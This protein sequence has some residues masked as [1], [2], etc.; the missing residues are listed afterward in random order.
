MV[1]EKKRGRPR[2]VGGTVKTPIGKRTPCD[3]RPDGL[4]EREKEFCAQYIIDFIG[5]HAAITAGYAPK[6]AKVRASELLAREDIQAEISRQLV[7]RSKRTE[8]TQDMVLERW[9]QIATADP[10]DLVQYRRSACRYCHGDDHAYHWCDATEFA[11]ACAK[12]RDDH[13]TEPDDAGG[14]GYDHSAAPHPECPRCR[15]AGR[16]GLFITDTR[17]AKGPARLLYAGAKQTKDGIE[18]KFQD[19]AKAMENVA[20]HLGMFKQDGGGEQPGASVEIKIIGGLP[21]DGAA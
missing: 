10:N 11:E 21:D 16:G 15:G 8:I 6:S 13:K 4:N 17:Q 2:R 7:E 1:G 19:Q 5:T 14:Y 9:W 12:A 3:S 18:I 20:R